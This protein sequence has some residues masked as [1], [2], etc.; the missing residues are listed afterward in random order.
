MDRYSAIIGTVASGAEMQLAESAGLDAFLEKRGALNA[1]TILHIVNTQLREFEP[2]NGYD[3]ETQN[4]KPV[5]VRYAPMHLHKMQGLE[6]MRPFCAMCVNGKE[7][8]AG[9]ETKYSQTFVFSRQQMLQGVDGYNYLDMLFGT[10]LLSWQTLEQ[11]RNGGMSLEC[12]SPLR[13]VTPRIKK[14][15]LTA[16]L[17]TVEA[18]YNWENV[19]IRLEPGFSFNDRAMSLLAGIYSLIQPRF[20]A[21]VGYATYQNPAGIAGIVRR[22]SIRIFVLPA[23]ESLDKIPENF[24][25]LD[26]AKPSVQLKESSLTSTLY[27]WTQIPWEQRQCATQKLFEEERDYT[28]AELFVRKSEAFFSNMSSAEQWNQD[29]SKEGSF[30]SLEELCAEYEAQ[31]GYG[32]PWFEQ[33][34]RDRIGKLIESI[35]P[36]KS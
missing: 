19:A 14:S 3:A 9:R 13:K 22:N 11:Y 26:T 6:E 1:N 35:Q 28:D 30:S 31:S 21:E 25:I 10:E 16:V 7:N 18:I 29:P 4:H 12:D 34:F 36:W 20:A 15:D 2:L 5:A 32:V 17:K 27:K 33:M 8:R 23:G 24:L